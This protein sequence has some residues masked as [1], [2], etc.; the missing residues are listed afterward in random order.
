MHGNKAMFVRGLCFFH[1]KITTFAISTWAKQILSQA[2]NVSTLL[3]IGLGLSPCMVPRRDNQPIFPCPSAVPITQS[4]TLTTYIGSWGKMC[5]QF[6]F[7]LHRLT[8]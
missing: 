3:S 4:F 1:P 5:S 8:Q 7:H 2:F 6:W